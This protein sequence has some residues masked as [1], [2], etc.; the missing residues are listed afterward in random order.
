[1]ILQVNIM[2]AH[3]QSMDHGRIG[4]IQ[5]TIMVTPVL[6]ARM[7]QDFMFGILIVYPKETIICMHG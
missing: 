6:A 4:I 1:M 3:Q 2:G 5:V 7:G